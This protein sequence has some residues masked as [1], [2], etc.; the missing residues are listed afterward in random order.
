MRII[1]H[2]IFLF[3]CLSTL[4]QEN[5]LV[6]IGGWRAH[7]PYRK[8]E[9]VEEAKDRIYCGSLNMLYYYDKNTQELNLLNKTDGLSDIGISALKYNEKMNTLVIGY[10]NGNIDLLIDEE[11]FFNINNVQ[12]STIAG[13]KKINDIDMY[14]QYAFLSTGIGMIKLDLDKKEIRE[15]YRNIGPDG[16]QVEIEMAAIFPETDS[17]FIL[18]PSDSEG[19]S[20]VRSASLKALNLLDFSNWKAVN[21]IWGGALKFVDY[22]ENFDGHFVFYIRNNTIWEL[23]PDDQIDLNVPIQVGS[24]MRYMRASNGNMIYGYE[25]TS[26]VIHSDFTYSVRSEKLGTNTNDALTDK[27]GDIWYGHETFGMSRF[28]NG[29]FQPFIP[30]GVYSI[31]VFRIYFANQKTYVLSGGFSSNAG[32]VGITPVL[33]VYDNKE[34][35]HFVPF[36]PEGDKNASSFTYNPYLDSIFIGLLPGGIVKWKEGKDS[37]NFSQIKEDNS[38]LISAL[39]SESWVKVLAMTTDDEGNTWIANH[40]TNGKNSIFK[41]DRN[42]QWTSYLLNDE[43]AEF[44]VDIQLD[45]NNRKWMRVAS[46]G[47]RRGILLWD[48]KT[49]QLRFLNHSL[50]NGG[51]PSKEINDFDIDLNDEVW[52]GTNE[53]VG[54]FKNTEDILDGG[55]YN[56]TLPIVEGRPLLQD[57]EVTA[58]AVDG[59]NRKWFG[60]NNGVFLFEDN[61]E[62]A[63]L[64]FNEENS[65]LLSNKIIDIEVNPVTGEVFIATDKGLISYLGDATLSTGKHENVRIYPNPVEPGFEEKVGIRGLAPDALVKITDISGKMVYET[66]ANGGLATWDVHDINGDRAAPGVYLIFSSSQDGEDTF[67]GKIA[68]TE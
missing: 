37:Q 22:I 10:E 18:I 34:W 14:Q 25:D 19:N 3:V 2:I 58:V 24:N 30:N 51:L 16:K 1:T 44:V 9:I 12:K 4:A 8:G 29:N 45:Q 57:E 20:Q 62:T 49:G 64:L 13:S 53:G 59:A 54:V 38:P 32:G 63:V 41:Y 50:N 43:N 6:G 26:Y 47:E 66:N 46:T 36:L 7:L 42:S 61:G 67:V 48:D 39:T 33:N 21:N 5:N 40:E 31:N 55:F 65:P 15:T 11:E 68:V 60:T 27:N 56:A 17:I 23:T 35:L 28:S 52:V